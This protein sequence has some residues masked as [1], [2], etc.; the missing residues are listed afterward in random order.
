MKGLS[1]QE[2][3]KSRQKY[4]DNIIH[5]AEP[6]TFFDKLKGSLDDPMIKLLIAIAMIMIVLSFFGGAEITEIIG[7]VLSIAIVSIV[8]A[9]TEMASD[10]EYRKLKDCTKKDVCK[11]YRDG[12]VEE[13]IIDDLVVGDHVILQFGDKIPADGVLIVGELSVDNSS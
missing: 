6:E 7:I 3:E 12:K 11:V 9:R 5:E 8:S 13:I 2:V 1:K 10:N 4:G